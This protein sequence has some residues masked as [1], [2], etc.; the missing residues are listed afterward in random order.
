MV[1]WRKTFYS[2]CA[3]QFISMAGFAFVMPFLPF[4][5]VQD[6]GVPKDQAVQWA[7]ILMAAIGLP[8]AI[9]ALV[10]GHLADRYGR[11]IMVLR[12]MVAGT[13]IVALMGVVQNVH[14]LLILRI[15]QGTLTGTVAAGMALVASETPAERSAYALGVMQAS[16]IAGASFGPLM[17]GHAAVLLGFRPTFYVAGGMIFAGALIVQY[18]V[19]E[20]FTPAAREENAK[21]GTY[22]DLF[23]VGGFLTLMLVLFLIN[24]AT[25][26]PAPVFPYFVKELSGKPYDEA[27]AVTGQIMFV[28]GFADM[29]SA[30]FLGRTADRWGHKRMLVLCTLLAGILSLPFYFAKSIAHLY[31]LRIIFGLAIGGVMPSLYAITRRITPERDIGK[32]FGVTAFISSAAFCF[33]PLGGGY[34]SLLTGKPDK[35]YYVAPFLMCGAALILISLLAAWR[36]KSAPPGDGL[37]AV[38]KLTP[39]RL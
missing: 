14:Q 24:F 19:K 8:M 16:V 11:K 6:L 3:A 23:S 36:V 38:A 17:G 13:V 5:I 4:Y 33:G 28:V 20:T 22:R 10:W 27:A 35:P 37:P 25:V 1:A 39:E 26:A 2:M 32:A 31:I 7:S 9:F 29:T 21:A 34:L 15:I 30:W 18:G 12:A